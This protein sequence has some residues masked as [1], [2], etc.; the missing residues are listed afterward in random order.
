MDEFDDDAI[1]AG[2][3]FDKDTERTDLLHFLDARASATD[4]KLVLAEDSEAPDFIC[5]RPDGTRI[6]VEHTRIAF[7][8][9]QTEL[10]RVLRE[11]HEGHDNF[12]LIWSAVH[13][14]ARKEGKRRKP[15]W[16]FPDATILV[17]DLPEG[18]RI[19][20]W[21]EETSLAEEFAD[22]GFLEI[23]IS[24][25]SSLEAYGEVTAIGLYPSSIW[26]IQGQGYLWGPPY[27]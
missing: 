8:S 22:S 7:N 13:A 4:E 14:I 10:R 18:D 27:K 17:L 1:D 16:E 3:V 19:E 21:P 5:Q 25:H 11:V 12:D 2:P 24:D 15:H 20:K 26:G 23:W 6:G 9:D